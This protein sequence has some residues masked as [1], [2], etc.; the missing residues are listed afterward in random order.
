MS[1]F[2]FK[3]PPVSPPQTAAL[4]D[5]N[6]KL[7]IVKKPGDRAFRPDAQQQEY[8]VVCVEDRCTVKHA[9]STWYIRRRFCELRLFRHQLQAA[10]LQ[11]NSSIELKP[12]PTEPCGLHETLEQKDRLNAFFHDLTRPTKLRLLYSYPGPAQV[13]PLDC[14]SG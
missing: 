2:L 11:C 13:G 12:L 10:L 14:F 4:K 1:L 6:L 7:D 5:R 8:F 3:R 9:T